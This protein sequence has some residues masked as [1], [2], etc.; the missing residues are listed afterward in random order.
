MDSAANHGD[1][2]K[3]RATPSEAEPADD[4]AQALK[5]VIDHTLQAAGSGLGQGESDLEAFR[6][7]ARQ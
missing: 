2:N 7:V 6:R 1:S 4:G 5:K 3:P